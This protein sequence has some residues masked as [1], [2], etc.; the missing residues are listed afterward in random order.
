MGDEAAGGPTWRLFF[1]QYGSNRFFSLRFVHLLTTETV[2]RASFPPTCC[3]HEPALT[4]VGQ[5]DRATSPLQRDTRVQTALGKVGRE[6]K[7]RK[8]GAKEKPCVRPA[9]QKQQRSLAQKISPS[10]PPQP[11][12]LQVHASANDGRRGPAA[13]LKAR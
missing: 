10:D 2:P 4:L 3:V 8:E 1:P 13:P 7:R 11:P 12:L 6:Q 9:T 5:T